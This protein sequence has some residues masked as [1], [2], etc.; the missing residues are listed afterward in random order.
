M[1][2]YLCCNGVK[3]LGPSF[4]HSLLTNDTCDLS[5]CVDWR[6]NYS[7]HKCYMSLISQSVDQT[8]HDAYFKRHILMS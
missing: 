4:T 7:H 3:C 5:D 8:S 2:D 1:N 6:A